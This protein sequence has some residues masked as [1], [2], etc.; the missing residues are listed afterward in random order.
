MQPIY[1]AHIGG[2]IQDAFVVLTSQDGL[3]R[4]RSKI[5]WPFG[6]LRL[7]EDRL[8]IRLFIGEHT[9]PLSDITSIERHMFFQVRIKHSNPH[10]PQYV[11]IHGWGLLGGLQRVA[12]QKRMPLPFRAAA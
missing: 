5:T 6:K 11:A 1:S 8:V 4:R 7:Y 12:R 10:V 9:I 3:A 2:V